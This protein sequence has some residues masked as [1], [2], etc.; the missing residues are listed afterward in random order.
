MMDKNANATDNDN[1]NSDI[2]HNNKNS[3]K[4][5]RKTNY[6]FV[7]SSSSSPTTTTSKHHNSNLND[8]FTSNKLGINNLP[9]ILREPKFGKKKKKKK[10]NKSHKE[11]Y[12]YGVERKITW[13]EEVEELVIME[14]SR[15]DNSSTDMEQQYTSFDSAKE[16]IKPLDD[17]YKPVI[18][19]PYSN[20]SI[21]DNWF[22]NGEDKDENDNGRYSQHNTKKKERPKFSIDK[23]R[24]NANKSLAS[25]ADADSIGSGPVSFNFHSLDDSTVTFVDS[26]SPQH[27]TQLNSVGGMLDDSLVEILDN[28]TPAKSNLGENSQKQRQASAL[29]K[30]SP[31]L[32]GNNTYSVKGNQNKSVKINVRTYQ[33]ELTPVQAYQTVQQSNVVDLFQK[34]REATSYE[35]DPEEMSLDSKSTKDTLGSYNNWK[36]FSSNQGSWDTGN[37][38]SVFGST[39]ECMF[40]ETD[41]GAVD[42]GKGFQA[43]LSNYIN[44]VVTDMKEGLNNIGKKW[45]ENKAKMTK[46]KIHLS[47]IRLSLMP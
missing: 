17:E 18:P 10:S 41:C 19:D 25:K 34:H 46:E 1:D 3:S 37:D 23:F 32:V 45:E 42:V 38:C 5:S 21:K 43:T 6:Q 26:S 2:E 24:R 12:G 39:K 22:R 29:G 35:L 16:N 36:P 11:Q 8:S 44:A 9:S 7:E 28:D 31:G 40:R 20:S 13:N 30:D 27:C 14:C 4:G 33:K 47:S 15:D